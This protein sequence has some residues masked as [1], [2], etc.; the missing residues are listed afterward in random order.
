[1]QTATP[2]LDNLNPEQR[3]A[4]EH[5]AA[6]GLAAPPL[7]VIAGAGSGKTNTLAHRVMERSGGV[8]PNMLTAGTYASVLHYLKAVQAAGTDDGKTVAAKM[9]E[10]RINDFYNK[11]VEIRPDGRVMHKMYLMKVK[12]PSESK[13]RGDFYNVLAEIPGDQAFRPLSES[14]CPLVVRK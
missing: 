9:R 11:D 1:V 2:Y 14:E 5:G 6:G 4:V 8:L 3:R 13:T 7:L 10:T 12:S